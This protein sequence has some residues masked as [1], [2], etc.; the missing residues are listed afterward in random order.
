MD[1]STEQVKKLKAQAVLRIPITTGL[2]VELS[3][4]FGLPSAMPLAP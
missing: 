2:T 4:Q 3:K 1:F